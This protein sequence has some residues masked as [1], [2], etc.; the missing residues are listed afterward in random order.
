M[1]SAA[2][3]YNDVFTEADEMM[4]AEKKLKNQFRSGGLLPEKREELGRIVYEESQITVK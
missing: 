4:Y 2:L 3:V 1:T